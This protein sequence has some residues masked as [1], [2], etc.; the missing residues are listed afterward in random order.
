[1]GRMRVICESLHLAFLGVWAGALVTVGY[2]AARA[3]PITK[4]LDP[5]VEAFA[6]YDGPH[7]QIVAGKIM[8]QA[9]LFVDWL[10]VVAGAV[11]VLTLTALIATG[12]ASLR[13][14]ATAARALSL[15][16]LAIVTVY[17]VVSYRPEMQRELHAFWDAAEAGA[18][19]TARR[20]KE[21]FDEMHQPASAMLGVQL[22]LVLSAMGAGVL[23]AI[24]PRRRDDA[25]GPA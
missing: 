5:H 24:A 2:I 4:D 23:G 13:R 12:A 15:A 14:V 8:N 19:E 9:F 1:M 7:W 3:F 18:L 16:A 21:A 17:T 10:G 20:H 22:L 6:A 25:G 11:A